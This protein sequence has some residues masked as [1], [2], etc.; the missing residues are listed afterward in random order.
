M[1]IKL[2]PQGRA[3]PLVAKVVGDV[4]ILNGESY[5]FSP[6]QEGET[7]PADATGCDWF[8]S[9]IERI[10]G[11]IHLTLILPHGNFAPHETRFPEYFDKYMTVEDDWV[12]LPPYTMAAPTLT[13]RVLE[14]IK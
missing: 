12:S 2:S 6:L 8:A 4:I 10:D 9:P 13:D 3:T 5:D 14:A 11:V 1:K 7:L